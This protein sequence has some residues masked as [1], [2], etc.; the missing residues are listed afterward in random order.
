MQGRDKILMRFMEQES[1]IKEKW[2]IVEIF[3]EERKRFEKEHAQLIEAC[4]K[5]N[6]EYN[7]KMELVDTLTEQVEALEESF[8]AIDRQ[9]KAS[10]QNFEEREQYLRELHIE[11]AHIEEQAVQ[12]R[13]EVKDLQ[14]DVERLKA[15]YIVR[16][17]ALKAIKDRRDTLLESAAE[18][19]I[20]EAIPLRQ[21]EVMGRGGKIIK[22]QPAKNYYEQTIVSIKSGESRNEKELL[23]EIEKL[24]A[25]TI[26]L[27]IE[28][29]ELSIEVRELKSE[30]YALKGEGHF[31]N[32]RSSL[33]AQEEMRHLQAGG[34]Q[35]VECKEE[36]MQKE[37]VEE[38]LNK[39]TPQEQSNQDIEDSI[40]SLGEPVEASSFKKE[41]S[42]DFQSLESEQLFQ[43]QKD[44][45]QQNI[46]NA[47]EVLSPHS[48]NNEMRIITPSGFKKV[49]E[50]F[51]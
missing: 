11:N 50:V 23:E 49:G 29:G 25:K 31:N 51:N 42:G 7:M 40:S 39:Q 28:K 16:Q 38:E 43:E 18:S 33:F 34:E 36:L 2:Q 4:E 35:N 32:Y 48:M 45:E 22:A 21:V 12:L 24:Q 14:R 37:S 13:Q 9:E 19:G 15:E 44:E 20:Y 17:N 30:L 27:E 1:S 3:E 26:E 41:K 47:K 5:L 10:K 8:K 6:Q 46:E